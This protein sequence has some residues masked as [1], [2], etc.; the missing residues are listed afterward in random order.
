MSAFRSFPRRS[1][2]KRRAGGER[3]QGHVCGV[4]GAGKAE[5]KE[6]LELSSRVSFSASSSPS[7]SS[8]GR[9]V[10]WVFARV[11][12][13]LPAPGASGVGAGRRYDTTRLPPHGR[14]GTAGSHERGGVLLGTRQQQSRRDFG[15]HFCGSLPS[16]I[17]ASSTGTTK[18]MNSG[19]ERRPKNQPRDLGD[20]RRPKKPTTR[21]R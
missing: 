11:L 18:R 5:E 1:S 8:V 16:Y 6:K 4:G 10:D 21:S 7:L 13:S 14:A 12:A 15:R 19:T 3:G 20:G 17:R 9:D 2:V